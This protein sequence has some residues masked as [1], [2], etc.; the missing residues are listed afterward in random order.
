M[1]EKNYIAL[2][3]NRPLW[4]LQNQRLYAF[5]LVYDKFILFTE[6]TINI[7]FFFTIHFSLLTFC[8]AIIIGREGAYHLVYMSNQ[9]SNT[10]S[11]VHIQ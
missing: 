6:K 2:L 7:S 3:S 10:V 1:E 11:T 8:P 5:F 9:S 4:A